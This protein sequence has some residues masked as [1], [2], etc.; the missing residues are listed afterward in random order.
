MRAKERRRRRLIVG[1]GLGD[2]KSTSSHVGSSV[3]TERGC[4][5]LPSHF[6]RRA[7]QRH[8]CHRAIAMPVRR[9]KAAVI[10]STFIFLVDALVR[11]IAFEQ[12]VWPERFPHL[13]F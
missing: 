7:P 9:S 11:L 10:L 3:P 12:A 2:G 6:S 13:I 4:S 5:S 8:G 1:K